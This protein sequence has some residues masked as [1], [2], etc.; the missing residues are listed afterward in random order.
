MITRFPKLVMFLLASSAGVVA[1]GSA[2]A[3]PLDDLKAF[4]DDAKDLA[5][6]GDGIDN[7]ARGIPAAE[8]AKLQAKIDRAKLAAKG[9]KLFAQ[10]IKDGKPAPFYLDKPSGDTINCGDK[11]WMAN[12][13]NDKVLQSEHGNENK[14][15]NYIRVNLGWNGKSNAGGVNIA[16]ECKGKSNGQ[17]LNFGDLFLLKVE[18]A[19]K[20]LDDNKPYMLSCTK[21]GYDPL[22]RLDS[23]AEVVK[24]NSYWKFVIPGASGQVQTGIPLRLI[25]D[26]RGDEGDIGG[27]CGVGPAGALPVV[28][29]NFHN[30]CNHTR[31]AA[32]M[33]SEGVGKPPKW[34]KELGKE[35]KDISDDVKEAAKKAKR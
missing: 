4:L 11:I 7:D 31:L 32:A 9:L 16:V 12:T 10:D 13:A 8:K 35:I 17:P 34:I 6:K 30:H 25:A 1:A 21:C 2:S 33:I 5:G 23:K 24:N 20:D 28:R 19:A 15:L 22:V 14:V 26:N 27:F 18:P 3:G 29:F